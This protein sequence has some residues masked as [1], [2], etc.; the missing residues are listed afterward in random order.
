MQIAVKVLDSGPEPKFWASTKLDEKSSFIVSFSLSTFAE[1]K[2]I[3]LF[4]A[5]AISSLGFFFN[6]LTK[7]VATALSLI[8]IV[9]FM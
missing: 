9:L 5:D 6:S 7:A 4:K 2:E 8:S 3:S 1:F